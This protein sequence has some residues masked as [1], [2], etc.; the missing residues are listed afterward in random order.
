M[1]VRKLFHC[2]K[3]FIVNLD[4]MKIMHS[5]DSHYITYSQ[6]CLYLGLFICVFLK[7]QGLTINDGI[8]YYGVFRLTILPYCFGLLG[9]SF[10]CLKFAMKL[11]RS[12][13]ITVKY[14]LSGIGL[15]IVGVVLTPYT[16]STFVANLHE[17]CGAILFVTQLLLSGWL[18][19][20]LR[21]NSRVIA[22][23]LLELL[24]GI[25]CFIYLIPKNGYL[26]ES[27]VVFQL[28]FGVLA[29]YSLPRLLANRPL[30][31]NWLHK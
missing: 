25:I 4:I 10:F 24:A 3:S 18:I 2:Q 13:L 23:S 12:D 31:R 14:A 15:L 19:V 9:A 7:P 11:K 28:C 5:V 29:M 30:P 26:F 17:A 22:L 27:Q 1:P 20:H 6:V 21:Y 8:S 16:L